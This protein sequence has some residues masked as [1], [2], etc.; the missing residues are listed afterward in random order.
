M[1]CPTP[2]KPR[3]FDRWPHS[4]EHQT[5]IIERGEDTLILFAGVI[6]HLENKLDPSQND[7]FREERT[8][9]AGKHDLN[10]EHA[11]NVEV[12]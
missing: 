12:F 2:P 6:N 4:A 9:E 8:Q 1:P 11:N 10:V 5:D 7:G 3:T